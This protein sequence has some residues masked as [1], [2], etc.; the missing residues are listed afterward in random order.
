MG[1]DMIATIPFLPVHPWG[2]EDVLSADVGEVVAAAFQ[3]F[4]R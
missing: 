4:L 3:S 2:I 1:R